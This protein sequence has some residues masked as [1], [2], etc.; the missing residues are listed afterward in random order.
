MS[1]TRESAAA[2]SGIQSVGDGLNDQNA[3]ADGSRAESADEN[4]QSSNSIGMIVRIPKRGE[5]EK[6][7]L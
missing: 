4:H 7:N 3:L 6:N 5:T 2:A 1:V